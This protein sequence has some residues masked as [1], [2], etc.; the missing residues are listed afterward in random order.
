[1]QRADY[2][3][4]WLLIAGTFTAVHGVMY[5]G[6]WRSGVLA[7][8]WSFAAVGVLLQ[9][10]W[11]DVFSGTAGLLLYLGIGWLGVVSVV[12]VG[13]QIGFRA[14]RPLW[15]AGIVYSSG[16]L[17]EAAIQTLGPRVVVAHWV[18]PHEI[19]HVTVIVGVALHWRFIRELL[20]K[21]ARIVAMPGVAAKLA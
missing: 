19:F 12:K 3:A 14:V 20:L 8:I 6:F 4:I 15:H 21:H 5:R 1:M 7:V 17:L 18:G 11:F 16:A 9:M 10:L 13:R 2:C